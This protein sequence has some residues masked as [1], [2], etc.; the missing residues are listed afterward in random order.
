[1][2][3]LFQINSIYT[4][5]IEKNN[6]KLTDLRLFVCFVTN[7]YLKIESKFLEKVGVFNI[8]FRRKE[9]SDLLFVLACWIQHCISCNVLNIKKICNKSFFIEN[10][11][12]EGAY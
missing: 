4:F 7:N 2:F 8:F 9:D 1:M 3:L 10:V 6:T 12:I 5:F 11:F